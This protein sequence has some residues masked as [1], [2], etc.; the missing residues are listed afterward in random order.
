MSNLL[1]TKR[2]STTPS[3]TQR[4][5]SEQRITGKGKQITIHGKS[6]DGVKIKPR[7]SNGQV[8]LRE[9]RRLQKSQE[10]LIPKTSFHRLVR[11]VTQGLRGRDEPQDLRYQAAALEALQ[12]ATEAYLVQMFEDSWLCTLHAGRVTLFVRDMQ[13]C[14]RLQRH[15]G[16]Y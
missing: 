10:L 12:E 8:A 13:L 14:R 1:E 3:T 16:F 6:L 2:K 4:V 9:I 5:K 7:S 11:E 15:A